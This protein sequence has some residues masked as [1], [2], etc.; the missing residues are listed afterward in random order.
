LDV[1]HYVEVVAR[2]DFTNCEFVSADR[3]TVLADLNRTIASSG[4]VS[5]SVLYLHLPDET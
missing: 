3:R 4:V 1:L 5:H 2:Q